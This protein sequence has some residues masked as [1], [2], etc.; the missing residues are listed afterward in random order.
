MTQ[1][2][3]ERLT[4]HK[5]TRTHVRARTLTPPDIKF[6]DSAPRRKRSAAKGRGD[7]VGEEGGSA[8]QKRGDRKK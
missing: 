3:G 8:G 6:A 2:D 7:W 1:F 4:A 5:R